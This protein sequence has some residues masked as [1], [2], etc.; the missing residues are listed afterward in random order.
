MTT[1]SSPIITI[2]LFKEY[3]SLLI[4]QCNTGWCLRI[5]DKNKRQKYKPQIINLLARFFF[6][7]IDTN[8]LSNFNTDWTTA[9]LP[10]KKP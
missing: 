7:K 9:S 3:T 10:M 1:A 5:E 4:K 6:N 2:I 8:I